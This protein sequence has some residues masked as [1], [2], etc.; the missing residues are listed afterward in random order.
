[1]RAPCTRLMAVLLV[2]LLIAEQASAGGVLV[3]NQN[4]H[5]ITSVSPVLDL[6]AC[7]VP[8]LF[9]RLSHVMEGFNERRL[10]G[11][12]LHRRKVTTVLFA[13]PMALQAQDESSENHAV[14][15]NSNDPLLHKKGVIHRF[16]EIHDRQIR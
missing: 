6:Q 9:T 15:A 1:M 7:A 5:R 12:V 3:W 2:S 4:P 13:L 10:A 16:Q 11:H 8:D 14:S